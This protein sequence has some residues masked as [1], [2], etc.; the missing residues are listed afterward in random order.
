MSTSK[1]QASNKIVVE[2]LV[3]HDVPVNDR[4][5]FEAAAVEFL[6]G[7]DRPRPELHAELTK[8]GVDL[9]AL[10]A[11]SRS[12]SLGIC[13]D[14]D[15]L[16]FIPSAALARHASTAGIS[17]TNGGAVQVDFEYGQ[18]TKMKY[19]SD[20]LLLNLKLPKQVT[21]NL[22]DEL[23]G[24][25]VTSLFGDCELPRDAQSY[26]D[27]FGVDLHDVAQRAGPAFA[28]KKTPPTSRVSA[29]AAAKL[30]SGGL[31]TEQFGKVHVLK[32]SPLP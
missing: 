1:T 6:F 11:A 7:T 18:A 12:K 16:Q 32:V 13:P 21:Q 29:A 19:P 24:H 22:T 17:L 9:N 2:V 5:D 25:L 14:P 26:L 10:A 3:P 27:V 23:T 31:N 15:A 20:A 28:S 30:K 8:R 4:A